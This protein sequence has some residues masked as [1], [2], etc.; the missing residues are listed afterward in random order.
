MSPRIGAGDEDMPDRR[1]TA[2]RTV[3]AMT[4]DG[5]PWQVKAAVLLGAPTVFA[6]YLIWAL[7]SGIVP[8]I[9][10][11]QTT[12]SNLVSAVSVITSDHQAARQQNENMLRVLRANCVN[13]SKDD[14]ARERCLQ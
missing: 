2:R 12:M 9:L 6:G 3:D 10:S 1:Q 13:Q 14:A 11:M 5:T 7:V 8:A 4:L